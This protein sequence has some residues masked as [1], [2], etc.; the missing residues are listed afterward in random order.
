ME[1]RNF[2]KLSATASFATL[3]PNEVFALLKSAGLSNCPNISNRKIV[4]IQLA[5]A[6][7]GINTI[8]PIS[9]YDIYANLRPNIKLNNVGSPNGIINLDS[10][11]PTDKQVGLHPSLT[12]F[13]ALYDS[14]FLRVIQG[15]GYP[16]QD[17]SHFKSTDLWLMGG[18]GTQANNNIGS[19]WMGRFM[20]NYYQSLVNDNYPLAIQLGSNDV[21]LGFHGVDEHDLSFYISGQDPA[22]FYSIINGL[23]GVAP[24]I[25]PDSEYGDLMQYIL[26]VNQATNVYSQTITNAFNAGTN[27]VTYANTSLSNQLKSVAKFISGGL[28]TKI[29]LVKISGFDTHNLQVE[30][31]TNNHLGIHA[32]L[33]SELSG[34]IQSFINDLNNQNLGDDVMAVTFSEFGR[35]AAENGNLG[36]DHGEIAPMF[37]FGKGIQGGVSGNN[38]NLSEANAQNNYQIYTVEHD[39]R[40]VFGTIL[41]DWLG[42]ANQTLNLTF[43]DNTNNVGFSNQK[44]NP[45]I[46]N[47]ALVP[48]S[49]YSNALLSSNNYTADQNQLIVF[50]NPASHFVNFNSKNENIFSVEIFNVK[51]QSIKKINNPMVSNNFKIDVSNFAKG[52]YIL[53]VS[54]DVGAYSRK[55][56][57]E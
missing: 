49:C 42:V 37:V 50:P 27:S 26:N 40:R 14:G 21:S 4:L 36:T 39:Y 22:G 9:Q 48:E 6:N 2:I 23:G 47:G 43:Y 29:Y 3:L 20:E 31:N 54:T 13:K 17:K 11:L 55:L 24:N 41:Q 38:V 45:F 19:G 5:G 30:S 12:G 7:D 10:T 56:M 15:V 16:Q 35:K 34:A 51:G 25:I 32:N 44:I 33:L 57:I 8:V 28:E 18:D 52:L 1:R 46:A 53:K